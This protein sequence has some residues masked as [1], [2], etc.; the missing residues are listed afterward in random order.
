MRRLVEQALAGGAQPSQK[1][2]KKSAAK[3]R[4]MA[5]D[6][7][8]SRATRG[9]SPRTN[10]KGEG[11]GLQRGLVNFAKF[12]ATSPSRRPAQVVMVQPPESALGWA[13]RLVIPL[14]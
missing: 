13:E 6:R 3:A 12:A 1:R 7:S 9:W 10:G 5:G 14:K 8:F 4:E 11:A 2:S